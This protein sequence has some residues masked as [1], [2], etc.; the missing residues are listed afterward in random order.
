MNVNEFQKF[1]YGTEINMKMYGS[2]D[3]PKY[4]LSKIQVPV[5]VFYSDKDLITVSEVSLATLQ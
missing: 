5:A 4:D 1:D 3:P 2:P